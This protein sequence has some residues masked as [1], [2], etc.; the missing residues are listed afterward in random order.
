MNPDQE[1]FYKCMLDRAKVDKQGELDTLLRTT[2]EASEELTADEYDK[3][4]TK[5]QTLVKPET[6]DQIQDNLEHFKKQTLEKIF[7][8]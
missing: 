3:F 6:L 5:L 2:I 8:L 4:S 7:S 1:I